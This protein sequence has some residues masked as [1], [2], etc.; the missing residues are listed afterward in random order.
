[1]LNSPK[2]TQTSEG[3]QGLV[4]IRREHQGTGSPPGHFSDITPSP[5]PLLS[6]CLFVSLSVSLLSFALTT[7]TQSS[8]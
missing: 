5:Q 2:D 3:E 1:M 8:W 4:Q 7:V 6:L